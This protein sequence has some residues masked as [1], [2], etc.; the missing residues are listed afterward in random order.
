MKKAFGICAL[1]LAGVMIFASCGKKC[2]CTRYEDG[3]KVISYEIGTGEN[4]RFFQKSACTEQSRDKYQSPSI[5]VDDKMV[6]VEVK[7]K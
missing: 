5:V 7:C 1:V 6:D 2:T 4:T 3:K